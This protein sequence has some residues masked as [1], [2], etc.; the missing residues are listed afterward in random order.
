MKNIR[1]NISGNNVKKKKREKTGSVRSGKNQNEKA[2][3]MISVRNRKI[4]CLEEE[5]M[6]YMQ[7]I[8][9]NTAYIMYLLERLGETSETGDTVVEI[10][11]D[12]LS[13]M[14]G[15]Y[16]ISTRISDD[17]KNYIITLIKTQEGADDEDVANESESAANSVQE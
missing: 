10:S 12:K 3:H 6:G 13:S 17:E 14:I 7:I 8:G 4:K 16:R 11:R 15:A 9:I 1:K 2:M 5:I